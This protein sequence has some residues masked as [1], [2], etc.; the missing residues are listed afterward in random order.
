MQYIF[1]AGVA[2]FQMLLNKQKTELRNE[3]QIQLLTP[4]LNTAKLIR[5]PVQHTSIPFIF[6]VYTE[7]L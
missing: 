5:D 3:K 6:P 4:A 2:H 1:C 7:V